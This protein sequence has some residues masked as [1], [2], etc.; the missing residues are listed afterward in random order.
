MRMIPSW[1]L[2]AF[3]IIGGAIVVVANTLYPLARAQEDK[4]K[5]A[6]DAKAI[7][8]PEIKHNLEIVNGIKL[9]LD[10]NNIPY[11][12]L[13]VTAWETISKGGLLVGLKADEITKLLHVYGLIYRA[14]DQSAK[15]LDTVAGVQSALQ[16]AGQTRM[17][18]LN[19]LNTVINELQ[20]A[21][22]DL[23]Q[24]FD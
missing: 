3:I 14:N 23:S 9:A 5:L 6:Q 1:V 13:D 11:E 24:H 18:F 17:M 7:L 22:S 2:F 20:P 10:A 16:N 15:L 12:L 19:G 8:L 21:L 4:Q